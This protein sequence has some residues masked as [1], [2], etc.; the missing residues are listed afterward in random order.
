M[1][2]GSRGVGF[3]EN[4]SELVVVWQNASHVDWGIIRSGLVGKKELVDLVIVHFRE[5]GK[6]CCVDKGN[7]WSNEQ[8][9][10]R[11]LDESGAVATVSG[12]VKE[13]VCN[14]EQNLILPNTQ[15]INGL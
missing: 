1:W 6:G 11:R 12:D 14:G 2:S 9:Q 8:S 5:M 7:F 3:A 15:S 13:S 4:V 10:S